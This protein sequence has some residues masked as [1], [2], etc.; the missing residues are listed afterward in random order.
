M[1]NTAYTK[2]VFAF[3]AL[4]FVF[5]G[6][7]A[8]VTNASQLAQ[9][10][11]L[12][13]IVEPAG[14][15]ARVGESFRYEIRFI[16]EVPTIYLATGL[17]RGLSIN[18]ERGI[19]SGVP[20]EAGTF[21][22]LLTARGWHSE[23]SATLRLV[24]LD[25]RAVPPPTVDPVVGLEGRFVPSPEKGY[26]Y[27]TEI[28]YTGFGDS[29]QIVLVGLAVLLWGG[30]VAFVLLRPEARE[31]IKNVIVDRTS[32]APT[33][34]LVGPQALPIF[35]M[36]LDDEE[37]EMFSE[38]ISAEELQTLRAQAN[39]EKILF[40]ERALGSIVRT[41][42]KLGGSSSELLTFVVEKAKATYPREDGYIKIDDDRMTNILS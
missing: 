12:E 33:F 39:K 15:Q 6:T 29:L 42:Q 10:M 5:G 18:Q 14:V 38:S 24:V 17:P 25:A 2:A 23:D 7:F 3:A 21:N 41:S 31:H 32:A 11:G 36:P 8:G 22:V 35:T 1:I 9:R 34:A 40:S 27:L 13:V 37:E 16:G 20:R 28:P 4:A 19:I 30:A 26:V